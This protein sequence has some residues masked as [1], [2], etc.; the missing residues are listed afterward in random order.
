MEK[1]ENKILELTET[2]LILKDK[3]IEIDE[4]VCPPFVNKP[5]A[6]TLEEFEEYRNKKKAYDDVVELKG[7]KKKELE[8][9]RDNAKLEIIKSLPASNTWFLMDDK[10]IAIGHRSD[11][12][13]SSHGDL[14]IVKNPVITE[15]KE[16]NHQIIS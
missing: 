9:N 16:I 6:A 3:I 15:L 14:L 4:M 2:Y 13:P 7:T 12:W 10:K 1:L 11:D 8:K 5:I